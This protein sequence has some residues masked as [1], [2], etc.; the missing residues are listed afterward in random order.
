VTEY[1]IP[2]EPFDGTIPRPYG[3]VAGPDGAIWFTDWSYDPLGAY[4]PSYEIGRITPDGQISMFQ[5]LLSFCCLWDPGSAN[6]IT[7]GSDGALWWVGEW[8][9][10]RITTSGAAT[11]YDNF[12]GLDAIVGGSDGALWF[13]NDYAG[14]VDRMTTG[15]TLTNPAPYAFGEN[16]LPLGDI[17]QGPDG[18]LWFTDGR[19]YIDRAH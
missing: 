9:V 11:V 1:D 18:A 2:P 12:A 7:V 3:I 15:G 17:V 19:G 16:N 13:T 10:G 6:N 4:Y 14:E 5:N 8:L